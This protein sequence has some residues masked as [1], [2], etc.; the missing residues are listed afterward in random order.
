MPS[1]SWL[2]RREEK[3]LLLPAD[4]LQKP[5]AELAKRL[6]IDILEIA[7]RASEQLIEARVIAFEKAPDCLS[8]RHRIPWRQS[9]HGVEDADRT[10]VCACDGV[11]QE[12]VV[13][14]FVDAELEDG[15]IAGADF[16]GLDVM[17]DVGG[18]SAS[19]DRAEHCADDVE[20]GGTVRACI[21][22]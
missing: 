17:K 8:V 11:I 19:I 16:K 1:L 5:P 14:R 22:E 10:L 9:G 3:N 20:A 21:D 6:H 15:A 7:A 13:A 18:V 12:G 4:V 2:H